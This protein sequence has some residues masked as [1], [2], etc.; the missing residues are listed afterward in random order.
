MTCGGGGARWCSGGAV[1]CGGQQQRYHQHHI[2][3]D[4]VENASEFGDEEEV[5]TLRADFQLAKLD[6]LYDSA[7]EAPCIFQNADLLTKVA[8][9]FLALTPAKVVSVRI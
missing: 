4:D 9:A 2:A 5:V 6:M 3:V 1:V 8:F 7:S